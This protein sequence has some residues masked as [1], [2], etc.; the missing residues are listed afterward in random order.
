MQMAQPGQMQQG[1]MIH[2]VLTDA[3]R[4][5][6]FHLMT[7]H[8]HMSQV[9]SVGTQEKQLTDLLGPWLKEKVANVKSASN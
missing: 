2:K 5:H 9:Y 6:M 7:T 1:D 8:N 3:G 4:P